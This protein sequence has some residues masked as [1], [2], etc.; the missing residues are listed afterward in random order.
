[1]SQLQG[2]SARGGDAAGN[3]S[4]PTVALLQ[5]ENEQLVLTVSKLRSDLADAEARAAKARGVLP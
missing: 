3:N 2:S 1:M 4:G 5:A